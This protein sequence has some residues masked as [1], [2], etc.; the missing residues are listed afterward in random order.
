M[1]RGQRGERHPRPGGDGVRE[2]QAVG[3]TRAAS[4]FILLTSRFILQN[5]Y[6]TPT[7]S[8]LRNCVAGPVVPSSRSI[9]T[10]SS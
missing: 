8:V 5:A 9:V 1:K 6:P 2:D 7:P 4:D 3:A 10:F